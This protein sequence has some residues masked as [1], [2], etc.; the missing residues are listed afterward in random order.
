MLAAY[1]EN[2]PVPSAAPIREQIRQLVTRPEPKN[3]VPYKL[4]GRFAWTEYEQIAI[5]RFSAQ[6][7]TIYNIALAVDPNCPMKSAAMQLVKN[8][9]CQ[10]GEVL[11]A[12]PD[13]SIPAEQIDVME[14]AIASSQPTETFEKK[15][16][17]PSVISGV[18]VEA[19]SSGTTVEPKPQ[20][21]ALRTMAAYPSGRQ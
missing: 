21:T 12:F 11:A 14:F 9:L 20:I 8:V 4:S 2:A 5:Q 18:L 17:I 7:Q 13:S 1:R 15:C 19:L 3:I 16:R 10:L 6:G